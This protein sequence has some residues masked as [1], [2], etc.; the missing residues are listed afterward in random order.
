LAVTASTLGMLFGVAGLRSQWRQPSGELIRASTMSPH[1]Y[2]QYQLSRDGGYGRWVRPGLLMLADRLHLRPLP[3]T[4]QEL[5]R[6]GIDPEQITALEITA[7]KAFLGISATIACC[8]AA[9]LVPLL[10]VLAPVA[11]WLGFIAPNLYLHFRRR[12]RRRRIERELPDLVGL[13][14]AFVNAS[15]PLEQALNLISAQL[16]RDTANGHLL[17]QEV[18]RALGRYGLGLTIEEVLEEM[19]DRL[20][21]DDVSLLVSALAQGKRLGTGMDRLLR[22]QEL[23][24]R[25]NQRN[26]ATAEASRVS[27]KLMGVLVGVY[28]PQFTI[29]IMIPLFWGIIRRAFG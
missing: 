4:P 16:V 25:M 26:R 15:V 12:S 6:A 20:G 21:V 19:A 10:F 24:I 7:I 18:R 23:L 28:L 5:I 9:I 2:R 27:T 17:A 1:E 13:L 14:K 8:L 29:L 11:G 22:D 3:I